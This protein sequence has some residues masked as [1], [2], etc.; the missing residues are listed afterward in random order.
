[1]SRRRALSSRDR[2][3]LLWTLATAAV[4]CALGLVTGLL[5]HG[6]WLDVPL[7]LAATAAVA[8]LAWT[9]QDHGERLEAAT[10]HPTRRQESTQPSSVDHRLARLRRDLR[11]TMEHADRP[12][13][14]QPLLLEL[15][16]ER[17]RAHGLTGLPE[18]L[19]ADLDRPP[20]ETHRRPAREL[21][22]VIRRIE[23]L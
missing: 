19:A 2:R 11:D 9:L 6:P 5:D 23:E 18:R 1:M 20:G 17:A 7:V 16:E 10:W 15:A 4:L 3:R 21:D 12:D 8:L 13:A 14:V 22:T